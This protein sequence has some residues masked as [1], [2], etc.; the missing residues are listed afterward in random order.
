[1]RDGLFGFAAADLEL[2]QDQDDILPSTYDYMFFTLEMIIL[3]L[4]QFAFLLI[5]NISQHLMLQ[6]N[7][8]VRCRDLSD[9]W[10]FGMKCNSFTLRSTQK[11]NGKSGKSI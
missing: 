2:C 8:S 6:C 4:M 1:M 10:V 5:L 9:T 3:K 11:L 7:I